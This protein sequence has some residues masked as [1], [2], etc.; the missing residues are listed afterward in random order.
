[1]ADPVIFKRNIASAVGGVAIG[2]GVLV[3]W[4]LHAGS[5]SP[6]AV[7]SGLVVAALVG[8]YVRLADL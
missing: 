3:L 2:A 1:M 5:L 6:L 8:A 7:G 4:L